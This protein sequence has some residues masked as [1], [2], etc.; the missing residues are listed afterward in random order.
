[1][2]WSARSESVATVVFDVVVALSLEVDSCEKL[3][4]AQGNVACRRVLAA[5]TA[6]PKEDGGEYERGSGSAGGHDP[7]GHSPSHSRSG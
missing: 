7:H 6:D 2:G 4:D 5:G 3:G 1:V